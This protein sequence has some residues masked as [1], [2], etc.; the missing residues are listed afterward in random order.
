MNTRLTKTLI[1]TA[2]LAV[3]GL[4]SAH[5]QPEGS[6]RGNLVSDTPQFEV[7]VSS[8][9]TDIIAHPG[10]R[11]ETQI[12]LRGAY[13]FNNRI[14]VEGSLSKWGNYDAWMADVSAKLYLKNR[15]RVGAYAVGGPG[16]IFG[17]DVGGDEMT[18]HLGLGLEIA[19]G[20]HLYVRPEV[21]GVALAKDLGSTDALFALGLGWRM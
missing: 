18:V 3:L 1:L 21:R 12:G 16:I 20:Q 6:F 8:F 9:A 10:G 4:T 19:A 5:A 11:T 2:V 13:H 7:F 15:G 14:A 17:N